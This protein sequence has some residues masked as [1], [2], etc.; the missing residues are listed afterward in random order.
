MISPSILE[1]MLALSREF[2]ENRHLD[3][4]L[5]RILDAMV[6]MLR[7]QYAHIILL[8]ANQ[9]LDFRASRSHNQ[10]DITFPEAQIS[11][12]I[13]HQV[14]GRGEPLFLAD[15]IRDPNYADNTSIQALRIR[16]VLCVPLTSRQTTIGAI[17]VENRAESN[18]FNR[19]DQQVLQLIANHAAT[20]IENAM[21]NEQL[22]ERVQERTRELEQALQQ[23]EQSWV[24]LIESNRLNTEFLSKVVHDLRSP[25]AIVILGQE[26]MASGALGDLTPSQRDWL[27]NANQ[28]LRLISDLTE[29]FFSLLTL[30]LNDLSIYPTPVDLNDFM[31]R[32]YQ[33]GTV[34]PWPNEVTFKL[35]VPPQALPSVEIDELRI[36][37][38]II[39]LLSN[40]LKYT[41]RGEV[42]LYARHAASDTVLIGVQDTGI[43]IEGDL[44]DVIFE[45]FPSNMTDGLPLPL[46]SQGTG[47]GLAI[48]RELITKHGG[49]IWVES[50][51]G[52]GANFQFVIPLDGP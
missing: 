25:L 10:T 12:T 13:L 26:R 16:S 50:E 7:A 9:T 11:E 6:A 21:L 18:V 20:A 33:L 39:N 46:N 29:S 15:A 45:R 51:A 22:E 40:A 41:E 1:Q 4:L 38:V 47:L 34:L 5:A 31:Q 36:Q 2:A 32:M 8:D 43:G 49:S 27:A 37:Q 52:Q 14:I 30:N 42:I 35:D 48:C 23:L 17:Y 28:S 44:I 3:P 19:D 24:R